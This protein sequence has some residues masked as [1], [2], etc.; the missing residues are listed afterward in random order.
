MQKDERVKIPAHFRS[1]NARQGQKSKMN[2]QEIYLWKSRPRLWLLQCVLQ[3][4]SDAINKNQRIVCVSFRYDMRKGE[5][6]K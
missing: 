1:L 6:R 3:L 5:C 2:K 4:W